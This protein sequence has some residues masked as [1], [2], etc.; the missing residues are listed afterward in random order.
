MRNA[1]VVVLGVV[2]LSILSNAAN[3]VTITQN[4]ADFTT[5]P[6][7]TTN[8]TPTSSILYSLQTNS[9]DGLYRSPF[10]N[11]TP[12]GSQGPGYG[13]QFASIQQ[14][15][16]ALYNFSNPQNALSLLWGSPDA[17]NSLAFYSGVGGTG[18]NLFTLTGGDLSIQTFGHDQVQIALG[19]Q[20]FLSVLLTSGGN[21]FEF[22]NLQ[23]SNVAETPLPPALLLFASLGL[24]G[25]LTARRGK[26]KPL[27]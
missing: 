5:N 21:A 25:L 14:D 16:S 26:P 1:L 4:A 13:N 11:F 6:G 12:A 22:A 3:A 17:Y 9:V 10:E 20:S 18:S 24:V 7:L 2:G 23:A 27:A 8:L 19:N 15:G